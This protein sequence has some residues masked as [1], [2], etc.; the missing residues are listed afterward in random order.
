MFRVKR[1]M[2][3]VCNSISGDVKISPLLLI[4]VFK[5]HFRKKKYNSQHCTQIKT[6]N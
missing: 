6:K 4:Y 5:S 2:Y 1:D 3:G